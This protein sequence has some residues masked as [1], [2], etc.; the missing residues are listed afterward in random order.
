VECSL[1]LATSLRES[2]Q[3]RDKLALQS[4]LEGKCATKRIPARI[5]DR[6]PEEYRVEGEMTLGGIS[7]LFRVVHIATG[8]R[9]VL[10]I[11]DVSTGIGMHEI[12]GFAMLQRCNI[13]AVKV[14]YHTHIDRYHMTIL[15]QMDCTVTTLLLTIASSAFDTLKLQRRVFAAIDDLLQQLSKHRISFVDFTTDNIMCHIDTPSQT[16][17]FVLIDPQFA[18]STDALSRSIG[19]MYAR[20]I[21]R[22]HVCTKFA[23]VALLGRDPRLLKCATSLCKSCLGYMPRVS[24]VVHILATRV[25]SILHAAHAILADEVAIKMSPL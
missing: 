12:L 15:E 5:L 10:K 11:T 17:R 25:P 23:G 22:V 19:A 7:R 16:I 24:E 6:M 18:V 4:V 20:N 8:H 2:Q 21:D 13:P 14:L 3:L 1:Q 9:H